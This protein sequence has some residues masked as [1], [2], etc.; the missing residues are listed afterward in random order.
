[1][2]K[3]HLCA[4]QEGTENGKKVDMGITMKIGRNFYRYRE[5]SRL[6]LAILN[7]ARFTRRDPQDRPLVF[8]SA[9]FSN[10]ARRCKM[11]TE[12]YSCHYLLTNAGNRRR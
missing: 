12:I 5:V 9:Y 7:F 1:M 6:R 8:T 10:D 4:A 2:Q 11:N 3:P